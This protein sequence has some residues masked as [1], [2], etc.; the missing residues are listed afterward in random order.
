[1][2]LLAPVAV[3]VSISAV[4]CSGKDASDWQWKSMSGTFMD[5]QVRAIG[6]AFPLPA[7]MQRVQR[8]ADMTPAA[9][10]GAGLHQV[11]TTISEAAHFIRDNH[12]N[13][14]DVTFST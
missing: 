4:L 13:R 1:M 11:H 3:C 5:V 9:W 10:C 7:L 6:F 2:R 8:S 12:C 14:P